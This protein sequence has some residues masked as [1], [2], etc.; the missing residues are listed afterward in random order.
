MP[1]SRDENSPPAEDDN[2]KT[3]NDVKVKLSDEEH[4]EFKW[5]LVTLPKKMREELL[6]QLR[7]QHEMKD[8]SSNSQVKR[9][10]MKDYEDEDKDD[11]ADRKNEEDRELDEDKAAFMRVANARSLKGTIPS[12]QLNSG[13]K[14]TLVS[15]DTSDITHARVILRK[16]WAR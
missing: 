11:D 9:N 6:A 5:H 4:V 2:D 10:L 8:D 16:K 15:R 14:F 7:F 12:G 1:S 13:F 3:D